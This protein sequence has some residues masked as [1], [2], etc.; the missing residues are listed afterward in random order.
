MATLTV[1]LTECMHC[2]NV[3]KTITPWKTI[4]IC[5][6]CKKVMALLTDARYLKREQ[7][8]HRPEG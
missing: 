3:Q 2:G 7:N 6:T 4:P 8:E 5:K 1:D